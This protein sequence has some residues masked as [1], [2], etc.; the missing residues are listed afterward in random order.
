MVDDDD[1]RD[2]AQ[3][4][5]EGTHDVENDGT[6]RMPGES[7]EFFARFIM[8]RDLGAQRTL[9]K[10]AQASKISV[11]AVSQ[12]A[13]RF[14]WRERA[15]R[16]DLEQRRL[17]DMET[18]RNRRAAR[19]RQIRLGQAMQTVAAHGLLELQKKIAAG[20]P[21]HLTGRQI[22]DLAASGQALERMSLGEE[23]DHELAPKIVVKIINAEGDDVTPPPPNRT[24]N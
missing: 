6:S 12:V 2:E 18:A 22:A 13:A 19:E 23:Y 15:W 8:Y 5:C 14:H 21:L 16:F 4:D 11:S 20:V 24:V 1:V 7:S 17:D 3:K 10:I 9:T